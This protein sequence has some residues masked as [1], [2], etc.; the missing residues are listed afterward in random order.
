VLGAE[1]T[2][3]RIGEVA[4]QYLGCPSLPSSEMSSSKVCSG[5]LPN[6]E[7]NSAAVGGDPARA[8]SR[9]ISISR[10]ENAE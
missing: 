6:R 2:K 4:F 8:S 5:Q 3:H 1:E 10:L 7:S 9:E